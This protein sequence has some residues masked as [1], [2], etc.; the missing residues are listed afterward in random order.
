MNPYRKN[1]YKVNKYKNKKVTID[2][3]TFDSK[4]EGAYYQRLKLLKKSGE[5]L[6]FEMQKKYVLIDKFKN[7]KTNKTVR[8]M[9][10]YPDFVVQYANGTTEVI[11]VK[12]KQT[13]VFKI[14]AKLFMK[15]YNIPLLLAKY[16]GRRNTF[17]HTYF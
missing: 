17:K 11:D 5:V 4:A 13:Q 3:V 14:K 16:D 15:R 9:T 10:Y 1:P 7:P 6:S 12:G 8:S 2:G